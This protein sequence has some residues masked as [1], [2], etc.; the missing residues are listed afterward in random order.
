MLNKEG[1][2][3]LFRILQCRDVDMDKLE[4]ILVDHACLVD[5]YKHPQK[6][7]RNATMEATVSGWYP[8]EW[9][10]EAPKT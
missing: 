2:K 3:N 5:P 1:P 6:G 9:D 7:S 10:E 8:L 4:G